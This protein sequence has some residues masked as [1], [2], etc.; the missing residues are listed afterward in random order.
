MRIIAE[1][2]T[3][4]NTIIIHGIPIHEQAIKKGR[5]EEQ[6]ETN[7]QLK[8]TLD[9]MKILLLEIGSFSA[10]RLPILTRK[11][12]QGKDFTTTGIR[13]TLLNPRA[14][15]L[16]Y[17]GLL[18]FGSEMKNIKVQ[19]AIPREL[20]PLKKSLEKISRT[21]RANSDIQTRIALIR[22][23]LIIRKKS[24]GESKYTTIAK[25][26][27]EETIKKMLN[28]DQD[29]FNEDEIDAMGYVKKNKKSSR[30]RSP[31]PLESHSKRR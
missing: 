10:Y 5:I 28:D 6:S 14:R 20:I 3:L 15:E 25:S 8:T 18:Q 13:L 26:L 31:S 1:C 23:E 7:D 19:Q 12:K 4:A 21:M 22:G 30:K 2:R 29:A 16:I 17:K 11:V 24:K 9:K 27:V